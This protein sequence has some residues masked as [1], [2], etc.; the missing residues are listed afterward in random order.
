MKVDVARL[1]KTLMPVYGVSGRGRR[2]DGADGGGLM[3]EVVPVV[4]GDGWRLAGGAGAG[5]AKGRA[6]PLA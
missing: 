1:R 3:G 6:R 2:C 4:G 5:G